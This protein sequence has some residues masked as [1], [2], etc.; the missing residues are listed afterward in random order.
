MS[1]LGFLV[2]LGTIDLRD[3]TL[4]YR[5]QYR[6]D[7]ICLLGSRRALKTCLKIRFSKHIEITGRKSKRKIRAKRHLTL[8][9]ERNSQELPSNQVITFVT[10]R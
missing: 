2:S 7:N 9:T 3:V 5:E 1:F 6:E 10:E 4:H 8:Q